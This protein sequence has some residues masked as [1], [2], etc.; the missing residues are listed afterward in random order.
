MEEPY[1]YKCELQVTC[2]K[3]LLVFGVD[4]REALGAELGNIARLLQYGKMQLI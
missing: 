4:H 3:S 2:N 1:H